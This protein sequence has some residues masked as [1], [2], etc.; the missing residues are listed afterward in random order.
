MKKL[1]EKLASIE[2]EIT[3]E[4]GLCSVFALLLREDAN[5]QWDLVVSAP[6]LPE[7]HL[8]SF[9]YVVN[10]LYARL[11]TQELVSL[12]AVII[13][14]PN[15][16]VIQAIHEAI[17]IT[18]GLAELRDH[19]FADVSITRG[20]IITSTSAPTATS[21]TPPQSPRRRRRAPMKPARA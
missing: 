19:L 20:Y 12:N 18:H 7:D 4:N 6:W 15:N 1:L 9:D 21:D 3:D 10:K 8:D 16:P 5:A 11:D 2:R 17:Q 14:K 13:L